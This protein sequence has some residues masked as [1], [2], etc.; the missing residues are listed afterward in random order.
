MNSQELAGFR[1]LLRLVLRRDRILLI[2]WTVGMTGLVVGMV[3]GVRA[4]YPTQQA[5][6]AFAASAMAN[7]SELSLRGPIFQASVGGLLAWTLASSGSLVNAV[8][9][10]LLA[11]RNTRTDEHAGRAEILGAAPVG[12]LARP[13]AAIAAPSLTAVAS[14]VL[15]FAGLVAQGLPPAGSA[16][17]AAILAANAILF[18]ALG[19]LAGQV[20]ESPGA[21][22]ALG[23]GILGVAF[24]LAAVGDLAGTALV[25]ASPLGWAR[26][27]QAFAGD[28]GWVLLLPAVSAVLVTTLAGVVARRRDLGSGLLRPR[29]APGAAAAWLSSPM[30][31]AWRRQRWALVGWTGGLGALGLLM[32]S[33]T[34]SLSAQLDTP[35]F[36][37][38]ARRVGGGVGVGR[39]FFLFILYVLAQ[40][41]TA[42]ALAAVLQLRTDESSGLADLM[43]TTPVPPLRWVAAQAVVA[44]GVGAGVVAGIGLGASLSSGDWGVLLL[45]L[46]YLP[47]IVF[48]VGLAVGFIGWLPRAAAALSWGFLGVL[49]LF[50]LLSE[51]GLIGAA[52][53]DLSPFAL[54]FRGLVGAGSWALAAV[55]LSLAGVLMGALG[56]FG[57]RRRDVTNA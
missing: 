8:I 17:L 2:T 46:G 19:V 3:S 29:P 11:V 51:F 49:L 25:W 15:S 1:H 37:E 13:A 57:M 22:R 42:A 5:M 54:L 56:A 24:T 21:A 53:M 26:H 7:A 43:F 55:G 14:A 48:L 34:G 47:A 45:S 28:R 30:A 35:A 23:F 31:L 6:D 9:G 10:L 52:T 27:A 4:G 33:V 50:D 12:R 39:A 44:V 40:V 41:A 38:F 36:Q 18:C 20:A 32:G 16:L